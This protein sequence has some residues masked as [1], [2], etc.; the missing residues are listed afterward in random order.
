MKNRHNKLYLLLSDIESLNKRYYIELD[1]L[2]K[3]SSG[4]SIPGP[5]LEYMAEVIKQAYMQEVEQLSEFR[6]VE[7]AIKAAET[8]ARTQEQ[9]PWR[10]SWLYRLIFQPVT[11]RAQ[12][13]IEK[14]A[15]LQADE[16]HSEQ[17]RLNIKLQK[18]IEAAK[19]IK[20]IIKAADKEEPA[21]VFNT[22]PTK[23][24]KQLPGQLELVAQSLRDKQKK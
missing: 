11:N 22:E 16:L 2:K 9:S 3:H 4:N 1:N 21:K 17:E 12:D 7:F 13:I 20:E 8:K 19:Q 24:D 23:S 6:Q 5:M 14:S 10:R 18:Q 15:E